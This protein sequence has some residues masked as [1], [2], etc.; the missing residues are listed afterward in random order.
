MYDGSVFRLLVGGT[1]VGVDV[2]SSDD[3]QHRH[4]IHDKERVVVL[5][6]V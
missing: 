4:D 2:E 1:L 6:V 3:I 5:Y